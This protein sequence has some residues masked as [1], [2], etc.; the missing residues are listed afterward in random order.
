MCSPSKLEKLNVIKSIPENNIYLYKDYKS[1]E[2]TNAIHYLKIDRIKEILEKISREEIINIKIIYSDKMKLNLLE[3]IINTF[4]CFSFQEM[5]DN[6]NFIP[7]LNTVTWWSLRGLIKPK[8]DSET[9]SNELTVILINYL[10]TIYP[11][12]IKVNDIEG[13]NRFKCNIIAKIFE[14]NYIDKIESKNDCCICYSSFDYNLITNVCNCKNF[15]HLKCLI[16][17]IEEFGDI[18]RTCRKS[19]GSHKDTKNRIMFPNANIYPSPLMDNYIIANE[20]SFKPLHF[21]IAYLCCNRVETLID[22]MSL[23]K[24]KEYVENADY[25]ALHKKEDGIIKLIDCPYTNLSRNNH[26]KEFE[27]IEKLLSSK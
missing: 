9:L 15:I 12:L 11:E 16:K 21:A 27:M 4:Q 20:N 7:S 25:H 26:S 23:D 10:C 18:C 1:I 19:T 17:C 2:L 13:A 5:D 8:N 14:N 24:L 3:F 22:K 6:N